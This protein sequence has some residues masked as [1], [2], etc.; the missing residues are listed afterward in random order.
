M[1]VIAK[2]YGDEPIARVV[3]ASNKKMAYLVVDE[4]ADDLVDDGI[5][6]VGFPRDCVFRYDSRLMSELESAWRASDRTKLYDLW[7]Q[8]ERWTAH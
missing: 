8:C 1:R 6:G 5:S 7:T 3:I 4:E 2:A